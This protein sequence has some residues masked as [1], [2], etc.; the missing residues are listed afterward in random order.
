MNKRFELP[1]TIDR[2]E[3]NHQAEVNRAKALAEPHGATCGCVACKTFLRNR[4][5]GNVA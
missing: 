4:G 5:I 1:K 2:D 3:W